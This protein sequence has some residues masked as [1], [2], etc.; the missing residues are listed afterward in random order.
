VK[1]ENVKVGKAGEDIA[2]EYLKNKGY[3]IIENNYRNKYA[4]I[5]LI[6]RDRRGVLT[7]IEVRTKTGEQ[8]GSPEESIDKNKIRRLIRN[9]VAYLGKIDYKGLARIDAVCIVLSEEGTCQ[10]ITH[11]ENISQDFKS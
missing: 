11:Y 1:T 10:R 7:F 8:R 3:D 6:A 5:D 2:R 9:A 4:E